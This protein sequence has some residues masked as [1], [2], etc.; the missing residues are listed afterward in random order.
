MFDVWV[1]EDGQWDRV[2]CDPVSAKDVPAILLVSTSPVLFLLLGE[3]PPESEQP[4]PCDL[5]M[6][7]DHRVSGAAVSPI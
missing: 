7:R 2:D 6:D 4:D 1:F 5:L 3:L